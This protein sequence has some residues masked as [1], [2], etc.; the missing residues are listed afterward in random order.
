MAEE[1]NVEENMVKFA[2]NYYKDNGK[3]FT[4]EEMLKNSI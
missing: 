4:N 2:Y 1:L 3:L